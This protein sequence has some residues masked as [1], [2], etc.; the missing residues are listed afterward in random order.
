M[1]NSLLCCDFVIKFYAIIS[2]EGISMSKKNIFSLLYKYSPLNFYTNTDNHTII[3]SIHSPSVGYDFDKIFNDDEIHSIWKEI[4]LHKRISTVFIFIL[5]IAS[6][7]ELIFPHFS[8]FVNNTWFINA[9]LML[10]VL[11]IVCNLCTMLCA[12]IFQKRLLK[13]GEYKIVTFSPTE[14]IDKKYYSIFKFE[15]FK[16]ITVIMLL[17]LVFTNVSP[18]EIAKNLVDKELYYEAIKVT[19]FGAK[20]FPIAQEW[21]ALRGYSK[22]KLGDYTGAIQDY[23]KAYILSA[24]EFN[25][26]NFDNKIFVKY[27][28]GDYESALADFD[29]EI[30]KS[31]TENERDQFLWDKAQFLYNIQKY[32]DA[33][34]LY[35]ELIVNA[36]D[37]RVFLLKDRLFLERAQVHK[38]LGNKEL[39]KADLD[40]SGA[41]ECDLEANPIPTPVLLMNEGSFD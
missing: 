13:F 33:L 36:D 11:L 35:D 34:V 28:I 31:R 20:V 1:K 4:R 26:M 22:F 23:D 17:I 12:Y 24:D 27:Y 30:S 14:E 19:N 7:Y 15:L 16:A 37:D 41:M 21:Y 39:T 29:K 2:D 40:N 18:F 9:L 32:E 25:I 6:L 38:K 3:K 8:L 5:F 10:A